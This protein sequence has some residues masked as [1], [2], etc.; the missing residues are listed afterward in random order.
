MMM[1]MMLLLGVD[2]SAPAVDYDLRRLMRDSTIKRLQHTYTITATSY[3]SILT[4]GRMAWGH[5]QN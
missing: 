4:K 5:P 3:Q 2:D 1:T